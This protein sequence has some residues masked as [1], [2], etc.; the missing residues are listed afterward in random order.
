MTG[1]AHAVVIGAGSTGS[2]LAHDLAL[3]GVR[4]TVVERAGVASG[5]TGHNQA[6]LHSGGRYAVNDAESARECIEENW[7]L[8]R[9]APER[10]ELNDGLFVAL[11]EGAMDYRSKFLEGCE[12][13]GIPT[14]EIGA[15]EALRLEPLL[16]P[17]IRSAIQVP[18]GVF[19]PYR[20]CLSFLA[21]ACRNGAAIRTFC[22]VTGLDTA[23]RTVT[24]RSKRTNQTEKLHG[25]VVINA[26]GPWA[27]EVGTLGGLHVPL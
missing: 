12:A 7:T 15:D 23:N 9:I 19:D 21:T 16:N 25:D 17:H 22:E 3:R 11:D 5:A 14:R 27:G 26:G 1:A 6:Q 20:L 2:A 4:V 24:I 13:C 10:L 8:R 18:D